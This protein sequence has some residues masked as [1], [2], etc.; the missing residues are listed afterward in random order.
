MPRPKKKK[1]KSLDKEIK[2][3][4][5]DDD[6]VISVDETNTVGIS[7]TDTDDTVSTNDE[8]DT[9]FDSLSHISF[10]PPPTKKWFDGIMTKSNTGDLVYL[11]KNKDLVFKVICPSN[12]EFS[13]TIQATGAD[14]Q[15]HNIPESQLSKADKDA[16][17]KS[18][19]DVVPDPYRD[20]LNKQKKK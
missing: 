6:T 8:V 5:V 15:R 10:N 11:C 14:A 9:A 16:V 13:Y 20:W 3:P 19:W 4:S 1:F 12:N 2:E 7:E 18:H 17:W